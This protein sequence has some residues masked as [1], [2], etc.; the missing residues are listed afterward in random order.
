MNKFKMEM[1]KMKNLTPLLAATI[2]AAGLTACAEPF[3]HT[4]FRDEHY[5]PW[6]SDLGK[7]NILCY[8]RKTQI[9]EDCGQHLFVV[10]EFRK[11]PEEVALTPDVVSQIQSYAVMAQ[12]ETSASFEAGGLVYKLRFETPKPKPDDTCRDVKI[13]VRPNGTNVGWQDLSREV[14]F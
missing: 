3:D 12:Q 8:G 7:E 9:E 10:E 11:N 1:R 6:R 5:G 4:V 2:F 13:R 14:C